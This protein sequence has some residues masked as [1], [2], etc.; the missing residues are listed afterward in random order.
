MVLNKDIGFVHDGQPAEIKVDT[1]NFTKYGLLHGK[2]LSVSQDAVVREKPQTQGTS[3][4]KAAEQS[5][6]TSEPAGQ[7][8][9]YSARVA[10]DRT[11]M[12]ID[13]R[14]IELSPGMAVTVEIKTGQRRI[15]EFLLAPL[16]RYR[17]ESLHER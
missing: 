15:I 12:D 4:T 6:E 7:E 3:D 17:Q 1:F 11:T 13:G 5:A 16:L 9:V 2:V 14:S 10:L 8:F